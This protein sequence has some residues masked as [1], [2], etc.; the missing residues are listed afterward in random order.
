MDV[1]VHKADLRYFDGWGGCKICVGRNAVMSMQDE[2]TALAQVSYQSFTQLHHFPVTYNR[3]LIWLLVLKK[4][5]RRHTQGVITMAPREWDFFPKEWSVCFG[6]FFVDWFRGRRRPISHRW[7]ITYR[8]RLWRFT[9][10]EWIQR[11]WW[12]CIAYLCRFM[13]ATWWLD[14]REASTGWRRELW[15]NVGYEIVVIVCRLVGRRRKQ[16]YIII[17]NPSE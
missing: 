9:E 14:R 11:P 13:S 16:W 15:R 10:R 5:S 7:A 6:S 3:S 2:C 1:V 8:I 17:S 4:A 12:R